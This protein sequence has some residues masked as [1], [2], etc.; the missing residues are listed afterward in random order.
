MARIFLGRT[1][2]M[3]S[4]A[5]LTVYLFGDLSIYSTT[6]PKSIMNIIWYH[7]QRIPWVLHGW[8]TD[9][10]ELLILSCFIEK[11]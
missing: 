6:V 8:Q 5:T 9:S 11:N 10:W 7:I 2:L 3:A 1:G 4:Y